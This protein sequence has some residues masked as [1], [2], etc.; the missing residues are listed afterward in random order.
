[1]A[2]RRTL[3]ALNS[4]VAAAA[5]ALTVSSARAVAAAPDAPA[6][7]RPGGPGHPIVIGHRG[8]SGLRPEHTLAAYRLAIAAGADYVEP[9]PGVHPGRRAG[10]P[11]RERDLRPPRPRARRSGTI[12]EWSGDVVGMAPD[13]PKIVP[14]WGGRW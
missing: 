7:T 13:R 4:A 8:A 2:L 14:E 1:M 10:G 3:I 9:G 11:A 5:G 12:L 6:A